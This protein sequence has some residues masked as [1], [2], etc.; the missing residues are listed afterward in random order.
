M[1][2][3]KMNLRAVSDRLA[4]LPLREAAIA[5]ADLGLTYLNPAIVNLTGRLGI[6]H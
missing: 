5:L 6:L 4:D 2:E 3:T 1:T